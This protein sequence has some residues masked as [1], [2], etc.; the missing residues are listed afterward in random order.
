M[1]FP[2][3]RFIVDAHE[4][5]ACHCQQ[6]GRALDSNE[7]C[8]EPV[9]ITLPWLQQTGVRLVCATLFVPHELGYRERIYK[10]HSQYEMYL[11]WFSEFNQEIRLI[12]SRTDLAELAVADPMGERDGSHPIG[13]ILL[14]EGLDL[15]S[16]AAELATWYDRGVRMASITWNGKNRFASGCFSDGLGLTTEGLELLG[17]FQRLG[18]IL[19]ISHLNDG[20]IADVFQRYDGPLCASHSNARTVADHQRNLTDGQIR[21]VARRGG[22]MGLNLL[23]PL[24]QAG[25]RKGDDPPPLVQAARHIE[26]IANLAGHDHTG[27]GSDL[28]GGL[29]PDN[30][31]AGIE[32]VSDLPLVLEELARAG[33]DAGQLAGCAGRNWWRFFAE[34]LPS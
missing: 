21:E 3:G 15:L 20:G 26:H 7:G 2:P 1:E 4:D 30:T 25:W 33:W 6:Y 23:A 14:M 34:S 5:L 31:P 11:E 22:V 10:L 24:V 9:M 19:D 13:F 17:E 28:D 32:T 16:S 29:T 8:S 27:L 18:M 12:K